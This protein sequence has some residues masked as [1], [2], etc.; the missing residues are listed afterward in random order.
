MRKV[1]LSLLFTAIGLAVF[2]QQTRNLSDFTQVSAATGIKV[3]LIADNV[4]QAVITI[5][6]GEL[7]DVIT[8]VDGKELTV[9][10]KNS[11]SWGKNNR[12]ATVNVHYKSLESIEVSSGAYLSA[13]NAIKSD[14]LSLDGSS[15]GRMELDVRAEKLDIDISSGGVVELQGSVDSQ[16]ID[17]SSGG[18]LK[19]YELQTQ[20]V[21]VD[22]SS[23]GVARITVNSSLVADA[24]SGGAV[25]YRGKPGTVDVDSGFSG[26]VRSKE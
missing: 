15:G 13:K 3:V 21:D 23:G 25:T 14:M 16:K 19:A 12:K 24:S 26:S 7:E 2:G 20:H 6:H 4:S 22:V 5:E 8:K 10:F 17:V 9:K 11:L 18:I 1:T